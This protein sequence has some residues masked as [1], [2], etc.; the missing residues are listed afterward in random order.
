MAGKTGVAGR[1]GQRV[2]A[3]TRGRKK[4]EHNRKK[5]QCKDC[6][7]SGICEHKLIRSKCKGCGGAGICQHNHIRSKCKDCGDANHFTVLH[8]KAF[9]HNRP[10]SQ[11]HHRYKSAPHQEHLQ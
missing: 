8:V 11:Y 4:C 5:R 7:G 2:S 10:T 6:G 3:P 9:Y 1:L